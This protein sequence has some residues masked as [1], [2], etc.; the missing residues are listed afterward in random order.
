[1]VSFGEMALN[2][3]LNIMDFIADDLVTLRCFGVTTFSNNIIEEDVAPSEDILDADNNIVF[4]K[5]DEFED[6]SKEYEIDDIYKIDSTPFDMT[7]QG[8]Q[9]ARRESTSPIMSSINN[10]A[11]LM[12]LKKETS[13]SGLQTNIT[14]DI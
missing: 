1:M 5:F 7:D 6:D 9:P 13:S 14:A 4:E 11:L 8:P 3:A 12:F 10:K 2:A